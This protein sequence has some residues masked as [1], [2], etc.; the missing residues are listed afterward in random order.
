MSQGYP[1]FAVGCPTPPTDPNF[2]T[3]CSYLQWSNAGITTALGLGPTIAGADPTVLGFPEISYFVSAADGL[4][5]TLHAIN[6]T[7]YDAQFKT[8]TFSDNKFLALLNTTTEIPENS[9]FYFSTVRELMETGAAYNA[10]ANLTLGET[11]ASLNL[12]FFK[13]ISDTLGTTGEQTYALYQYLLRLNSITLLREDTYPD[14]N[15]AAVL[16]LA[17]FASRGL[18]ELIDG[19]F[20]SILPRT[21]IQ[22]TFF[23]ENLVGGACSDVATR[24][25]SNTTLQALVC[26]GPNATEIGLQSIA[27]SSFWV[28]V[29]MDR[30]AAT[31]ATLDALNIT[32]AS[33]DDFYSDAGGFNTNLDLLRKAIKTQYAPYCTS[34]HGPYCADSEIGLAQFAY[35]AITKNMLPELAALGI[36]NLNSV[37]E[38]LSQLSPD[39]ALPIPPE[40]SVFMDKRS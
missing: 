11:T 30:S 19:L 28:N 24:Y 21:L 35:S 34:S 23:I 16:G 14:R 22:I 25:F 38:L 17:N 39:Q 12:T 40:Y 18:E 2:R 9:L 7:L 31:N 36:P 37:Q 4:N 26:T 33:I 5:A 6:T 29:F 3:A 27:G 1:I 32:A 13:N 10:T 15:N 8:V 20:N